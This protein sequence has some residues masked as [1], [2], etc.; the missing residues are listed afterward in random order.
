[1]AVLTYARKV[2]KGRKV[3]LVL[4][5]PN[6]LCELCVQKKKKLLRTLR[7]KKE[8]TFANFVFSKPLNRQI[9]QLHFKIIIRRHQQL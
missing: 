2:R 6:Y 3:L 9:N 8:K 5:S 4:Y 1:M 7:A